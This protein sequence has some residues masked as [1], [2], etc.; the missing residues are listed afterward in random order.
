MAKKRA[1][2]NGGRM[3]IP[4]SWMIWKYFRSGIAFGLVKS[5]SNVIVSVKFTPKMGT[6]T[7]NPITSKVRKQM[8]TS[9]MEKIILENGLRAWSRGV[10][11]N[12]SDFTIF[13]ANID[14]FGEN[15]K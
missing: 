6:A 7:S 3:K 15:R 11:I 2:S 1:A 12:V 9:S 10:F 14:H 8:M 5:E 13:V 4:N